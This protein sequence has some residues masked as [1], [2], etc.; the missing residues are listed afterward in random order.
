MF[1]KDTILIGHSLNCDLE[2]LKLIHKNVVDTS[3]TFPH[4]N[5]QFKN[6]LRKLAKLYINMDIQDAHTG[7][8]S[9]EDAIAAMRLLIAKYQGKI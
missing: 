8:D 5:P 2:A 4:R 6:P 9:A 1:N 7:H 3:I